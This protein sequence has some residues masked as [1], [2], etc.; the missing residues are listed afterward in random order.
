MWVQLEPYEIENYGDCDNTDWF[1]LCLFGID[2]RLSKKKNDKFRFCLGDR[3][4]F[5]SKTIVFFLYL[6][7]KIQFLFSFK[8]IFHSHLLLAHASFISHWSAKCE[9]QFIFSACKTQILFVA[10]Y[11]ILRIHL[12]FVITNVPRE[13]NRKY[14]NL[15]L[16]FFFMD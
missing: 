1:R 6:I 13:V 7:E 10:Y 3:L 9:T 5:S 4:K 2:R 14:F 15:N 11:F 8:F 12:Q 16:F